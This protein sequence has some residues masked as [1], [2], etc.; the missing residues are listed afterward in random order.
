[1]FLLEKQ[2]VKG[3]EATSKTQHYN[4]IENNFLTH[5]LWLIIFEVFFEVVETNYFSVFLN[6]HCEILNEHLFSL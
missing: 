6:I 1:M 2:R 4:D 5:I 3:Y